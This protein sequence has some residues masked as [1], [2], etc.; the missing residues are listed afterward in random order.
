VHTV[1]EEIER[2]SSNIL[3]FLLAQGQEQPVLKRYGERRNKKKKK[4]KK[5][6]KADNWLIKAGNVACS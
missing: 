1:R 4:R 5:K 6:K 3:L 2:A